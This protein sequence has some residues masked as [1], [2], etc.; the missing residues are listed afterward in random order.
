MEGLLKN[1][2]VIAGENWLMINMKRKALIRHRVLLI[3][4]VL[5]L[6]LTFSYF[7]NENTD[8]IGNKSLQFLIILT[9]SLLICTVIYY[10]FFFDKGFIISRK[11]H[12]FIIRKKY[13][14]KKEELVC[15]CLDTYISA[16]GGSGTTIK[17]KTKGSSVT[18][19]KSLDDNESKEISALISNFLE[20]PPSA[21]KQSYR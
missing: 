8:G 14:I 11:D 20:L 15:I 19:L 4:S 21:I 3:I 12:E 9:V 17:L 6:A 5:A 16:D 1:F 7:F 2:N 18:L 13:K 10:K